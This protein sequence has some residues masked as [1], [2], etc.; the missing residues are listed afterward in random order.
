[1]LGALFV[2][3]SATLPDL[4]AQYTATLY[5]AECG[6]AGTCVKPG[7]HRVVSYDGEKSLLAI[8]ANN[9][10]TGDTFHWV[11]SSTTKFHWGPGSGNCG[12][13]PN[14][15][16]VQS[17]WVWLTYN[18]TTGPTDAKCITD[19]SKQCQVWSG[20]WPEQVTSSVS[21]YIRKDAA[22]TPDHL[23][24]TCAFFPFTICT[25]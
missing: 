7:D 6:N 20:P 10:H 13:D 1:M 2:G 8:Q 14:S 19:P 12:G 17:D 21:L 11:Q 16:P 24:M 3:T 23:E 18:T 5:W 4:P 22:A 15:Y 9:S 25:C